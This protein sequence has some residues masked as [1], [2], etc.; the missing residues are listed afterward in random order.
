MIVRRQGRAALVEVVRAD[1][2]I[3]DGARYV[4]RT[5]RIS[6]W[7][8]SMTS[9]LKPKTASGSIRGWQVRASETRPAPSHRVSVA[10]HTVPQI[11]AN[12]L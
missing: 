11:G 4:V 8:Y 2:R 7:S 9:A 1:G 6:A 12:T 10:F 3:T 5:V